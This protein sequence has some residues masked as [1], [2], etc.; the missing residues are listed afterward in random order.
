MTV[1]YNT[2]E[3]YLF[4]TSLD[5]FQNL[6]LKISMG[7]DFEE[8]RAVLAEARPDHLLGEPF[9]PLK[10]GLTDTNAV[11]IVGRNSKGA[12]IHTQAMK[13]L[14]LGP[15]RLGDYLHRNLNLHWK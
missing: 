14:Q 15:Q 11:W 4:A 6:G 10:Y 2:H 5:I 3:D 7:T 9:E 13:C 1:H 8:Y 12:V